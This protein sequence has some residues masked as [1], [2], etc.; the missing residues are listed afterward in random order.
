MN[1]D[2]ALQ[3]GG[4]QDHWQP[5]RQLTLVAARRRSV[6]VRVLRVLFILSALGII[7]IV[8]AYIITN[9]AKPAPVAPVVQ[10]QE[11]DPSKM[12][13]V[14]PVYTGRDEDN[15]GYVVKAATAKTLSEEEKITELVRP[16][17]GR[18]EDPNVT[19]ARGV[20]DDQNK[21]LELYDDVQLQTPSGFVFDTSSAKIDIKKDRIYGDE[22]VE[23]SG[24]LGDITADGYE[25]LNGGERILF[26]GRVTTTIPMTKKKKED[27]E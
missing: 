4:Q 8:A 3:T 19:A 26:N 10:T 27:D 5:S 22:T 25:V 20:Y 15:G 9:T 2:T 14:N 17:L 11:T 18:G 1:M 16:E 6:L 12:L 7:G 21:T 24:P 13:I 23:G